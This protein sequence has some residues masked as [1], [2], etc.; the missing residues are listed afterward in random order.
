MKGRASALAEA[1]GFSLRTLARRCGVYLALA[2]LT[3]Q[4]A[5]SFGHIHPHDIIQPSFA[6]AQSKAIDG[7]QA[8]TRLEG[9]KQL[10]P[11]LADDDE[12]C[13]VC[14]S[15]LLLSTS[16]ISD[17]LPHQPSSDFTVIDRFFD[18]TFY[19]VFGPDRGPFQPRAPPMS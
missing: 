5:L 14:F 9:W 7:R 4:L 16:F 11:G 6:Y 2:A 17:G 13:L 8:S 19:I 1:D 10:P 18:R 12:H 15:T 3:L